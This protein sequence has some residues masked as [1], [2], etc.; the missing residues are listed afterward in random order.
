M[1]ESN[2]NARQPRGRFRI[3]DDGCLEV[4]ASNASQ[5][6]RPTRTSSFCISSVIYQQAD[7]VTDCILTQTTQRLL[8]KDA[9][10][11]ADDFH[12]DHEIL[13]SCPMCRSARVCSRNTFL[14]GNRV[15]YKLFTRISVNASSHAVSGDDSCVYAS[16]S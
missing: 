3:N 4:H 7:S 16:G 2:W 14:H 1:L 13:A 5:G 15:K 12:G 6:A 9:H 8:R 10:G 11:S